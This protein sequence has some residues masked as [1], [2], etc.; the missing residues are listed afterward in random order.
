MTTR[1]ERNAILFDLLADGPECAIELEA[2]MKARGVKWRWWWIHLTFLLRS[3]ED[4]GLVK[5][6]VIDKTPDDVRAQRGKYPRTYWA[7]TPE[8]KRIALFRRAHPEAA[9]C[10]CPDIHPDDVPCIVCASLLFLARK[11]AGEPARLEI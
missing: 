10:L 1:K 8:Q 5:R 11:G 9:E 4:L 7:L 6:S 2:K 3:F